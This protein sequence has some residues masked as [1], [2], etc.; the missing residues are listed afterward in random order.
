MSF[1][2][3]KV[4]FAEFPPLRNSRLSSRRALAFDVAGSE[5]AGEKAD[6]TSSSMTGAERGGADGPGKEAY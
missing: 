1:V 5:F 6:E 4:E 3:E 2:A